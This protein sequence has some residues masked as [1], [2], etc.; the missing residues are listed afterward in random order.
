M[1]GRLQNRGIG[2]AGLGAGRGGYASVAH[3]DLGLRLVSHE[4]NHARGRADENQARVRN[5]L[6]EGDILRKETVAWMHGLRAGSAAGFKDGLHI[7]VTGARLCR[8][9][10]YRQIGFLHVK[11]PLVSIGVD[12]HR[13]QAEAT[14]GAHDAH[15][16]LSTVG[17]EQRVESHI[18]P[19]WGGCP[20]ACR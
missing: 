5:R 18:S 8:A 17:D 6:G 14:R 9:Q 3:G 15:R 1:A 7:A 12:G 13:A 4:F 16:D 20:C 19:A 11:A 2:A 10:A